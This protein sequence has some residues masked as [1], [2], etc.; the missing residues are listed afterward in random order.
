MDEEESH[1]LWQLLGMVGLAQFER[2]LPLSYSHGL[3]V[4]K[5]GHSYYQRRASPMEES[6]ERL[7][8]F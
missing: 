4:R 3:S 5:E 2:V 1:A 6:D 8:M 7:M